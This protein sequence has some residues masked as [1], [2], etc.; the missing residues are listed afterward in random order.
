MGRNTKGT[1][2]NKMIRYCVLALPRTGSTWLHEGIASH[3]SSTYSDK[4]FI[5]LGEFFTPSINLHKLEM[6]TKYYV[7][8]DNLIQKIKQDDIVLENSEH[9]VSFINKRLDIL[10]DGSEQQSMILKYMYS[11]YVDKR[12][13]DLENLTKIKNHNFIIV[14]INR[15]VFECTLSYLVSKQTN[16]WIKSTLWDN[17]K[18]D[19]ITPASVIIPLDYFKLTYITYLKISEEK[20]KLAE[21]LCCVTVDYK[22]LVQDCNINKVPFEENNNCQKLYDMDYNTIITNYDE[23]LRLKAEIDKLV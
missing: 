9:V 8:K 3:L 11:N 14:N 10:L 1:S 4:N 12:I 17:K 5:N 16:I 21:N 6:H 19:L 7:D 2:E 13:N 15:D 23:I 20:Q 18:I 22:T